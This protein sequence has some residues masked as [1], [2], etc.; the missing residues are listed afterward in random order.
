MDRVCWFLL[1][2]A[3]VLLTAALPQAA[4]AESPRVHFD[5][6]LVIACRDVTSPE[7]A[8]AN[9]SH[10]LV[11]ARFEISALL[12]AGQERDL[13][14]VFIKIDSPPRSLLVVDYLPKTRHESH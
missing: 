12:L 5:M 10:R 8:A 14:Q 1:G 13:T 9:P 3:V 7:F 4:Q 6:P 11:E 2:S